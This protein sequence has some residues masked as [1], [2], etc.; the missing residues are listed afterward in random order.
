MEGMV[1]NIQKFSI[2]DGP[3]IRT[4][5]FLKG[6]PLRCRW[7]ANPESQKLTTQIL[8]DE[9]KCLHCH[10]CIDICPHQ[11]ISE[12]FTITEH[13][14][15]T[16]LKCVKECPGH[17]LS[18]EGEQMDVNTVV[19]T[20]LQDVDFYEESGGGVTISGGEGMMQPAFTKA[21]VQAL[22]AHHIHV[23]IETTG[24][25]PTATFQKLAPLF[26]LLLFDVKHYDDAKHEKG[27]GVTHQLID[28]NMRYAITH[29]I[30]LLARIPVI[31]GFNDS[32]EDA[33]AFALY[34]KSCGLER[35][36]LLPFHQMGENK[37]NLLN[38]DYAYTHIKAYHEEDLISYQK[39]MQDTGIEAFFH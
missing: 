34:L 20:C 7:C 21:L 6:C 36:Q 23:A 33:K 11:C 39:V 27:T 15:E 3:G 5:V 4:T 1:F 35:V 37:Y 26:D 38:R 28:T 13:H 31:P 10:H 17:A 22:K 2:H 29:K 12:D 30:P 32:L 25:I 14:C 19:E 24:H 9:K 8:H 16:C 18:Y